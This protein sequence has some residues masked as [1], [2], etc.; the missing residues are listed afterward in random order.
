MFRLK[1][2]KPGYRTVLM[3]ARNPSL[4]TGMVRVPGGEYGL[5]FPVLWHAAGNHDSGLDPASGSI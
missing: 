4:V 5:T 1:L 3:A 2:E